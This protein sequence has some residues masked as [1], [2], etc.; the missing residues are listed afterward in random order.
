M[1]RAPLKECKE[2]DAEVAVVH[3]EHISHG[4]IDAVLVKQHTRR[5]TLLSQVVTFVVS[6]W[7]AKCP[8]DELRPFWTRRDELT[9]DDGVM[10]LG[11]AGVC[12]IEATQGNP[13]RA[14]RSASWEHTLQ[15]IRTFVRLLA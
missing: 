13:Q 12:P 3:A 6:G 2:L 4:P 1:S 5:D 9:V 14:T 15:A 10:L 11:H 8:T 7:P